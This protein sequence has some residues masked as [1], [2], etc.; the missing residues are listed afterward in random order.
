MQD[1]ESILTPLDVPKAVKAQAWDAFESSANE[2]E[3][4][5]KIQS[6]PIPKEA[7]AQ[8]WNLKHSAAL[9]PQQSAPGRP[10]DPSDPHYQAKETLKSVWDQIKNQVSGIPSLVTGLP[11]AAQQAA[12]VVKD[13]LTGEGSSPTEPSLGMRLLKSPNAQAMAKSVAAPFVTSARGVHSLV[14]PSIP[15][16]SDEEFAQ[17]SQAAGANAAGM[18]L[19]AIAPKVAPHLAPLVEA[20]TDSVKELPG[21]VA[22]KF[23]PEPVITFLRG[24]G[25]TDPTARTWIPKL[26][27]ELK[28]AGD[29]Q[30]V[31]QA[32]DAIKTRLDTYNPVVEKILEPSKD[33]VIPGS[34]AEH[35]QAR[36]D[37]IPEKVRLDNPDKYKAIVEDTQK[38]VGQ[39]T[40]YTIGELDQLRKSYERSVKHNQSMS[41]SMTADESSAAMDRASMRFAIDKFYGALDQVAGTGADVAELK[42]RIGAMLKGDEALAKRTNRAAIQSGQSMPAQ[43]VEGIGHVMR[44]GKY[45][46]NLGSG[47]TSNINSDISS[48]MRRWTRTP[49]SIVPPDPFT[50]LQRPPATPPAGAVPPAVPTAPAPQLTLPDPSAAAPDV[51]AMRSHVKAADIENHAKLMMKDFESSISTGDSGLTGKSVTDVNERGQRERPNAGFDSGTRRIGGGYKTGTPME[52][53]NESP[54]ELAKAI[55]S[56]SGK[57]YNHILEAYKAVAAEDMKMRHETKGWLIDESGAEPAGTVFDQMKSRQR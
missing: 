44:S 40:D 38:L 7:K 37:A 55:K 50:P 36:I 49:T 14:N 32:R 8:L 47:V 39:G 20:A 17:A 21:W 45:A 57:L 22:D 12:G 26:M 34:R 5:A 10:G 24:M 3:L 1:A 48:A 11:A 16:P 52:N 27:D 56:G 18:A 33:V 53:W 54:G 41:A 25:S 23:K 29:V 9:A 15:A 43:V 35:I 2:D 46:E 4:T 13:V 42:S 51:E 19:G 6:L 31:D 30:T 28:A